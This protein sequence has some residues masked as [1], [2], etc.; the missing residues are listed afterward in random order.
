MVKRGL[1]GTR[2]NRKSKK[3]FVLHFPDSV[4]FTKLIKTLSKCKSIQFSCFNFSLNHT[5]KWE[6]F[7]TK[8]RIETTFTVK[9]TR[10]I[11]FILF[12]KGIFV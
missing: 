12:F 9:S 7:K 4:L 5:I 10:Q 3:Q 1:I 2:N 8:Q 11:I 6:Y